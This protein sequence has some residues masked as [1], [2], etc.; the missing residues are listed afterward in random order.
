[1]EIGLIV[2]VYKNFKGFTQLMHTVDV[3][4]HPIVIPNWEEN[5]GVSGGWN[6]GLA[7]AIDKGLE[8]AVVS[9]DDILLH[10]GTILKIIEGLDDYEMVTPRNVREDSRVF[11]EPEYEEHPDYSCFAVRPKS[12]VDIHGWFDENFV[13]A[14]FEDND[15][16]YRGKLAGTEHMRRMDA[17]MFHVGSVTQNYDG[18]PVVNHEMYQT[19]REYYRQK[20]GGWPGEETFTHPYN[21]E[22]KD[23]TFWI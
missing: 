20:W 14:Y 13:P 10:P 21:R 22:D 9:N 16:H 3:P 2:P 4:I 17:T 1:M 18:V 11:D 19:N 23:W 6:I 8:Y 7:K 12:F 5:M 15:M